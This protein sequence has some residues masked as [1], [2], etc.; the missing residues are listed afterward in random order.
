M[1]F[2]GF[3]LRDSLFIYLANEPISQLSYNCKE[4]SMTQATE[5]NKDVVR[6]MLKALERQDRH[7]GGAPWPIR[8]A[9]IPPSERLVSATN[10]ED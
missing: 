10:R 5:Q 1:T 3:C 7:P 8:D 6:E 9:Q 4:Q 2:A